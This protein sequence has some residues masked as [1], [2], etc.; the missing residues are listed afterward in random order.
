M[1]PKNKKGETAPPKKKRGRKP[2]NKNK[3]EVKPPPKKRGRKPKGGKIITKDQ[4]NLKENNVIEHNIILHLKCNSQNINEENTMLNIT[5]Y[6]PTLNDPAAYNINSSKTNALMF[7]DFKMEESKTMENI[8]V[9]QSYKEEKEEEK[10]EESSMKEIWLKLDHLK[11]KLK[12]NNVSDKK[13]ACFWCTCS[14]DNPAIYIPSSYENNSYEV[15]GCFCSPQCAVSFLKNQN[16][17]TSTLWER[18]SLLNNMY[19][20]IY[21]YQKNIKPAPNPFYTL[22][23]YYGNLSI[24][25]YRKLLKNESMYMIVDKPMTKI[26]PELYEENNETPNIYGNLLN[27][28]KNK[29]NMEYRLKRKKVSHT[30]S[31]LLESNFNFS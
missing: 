12:T 8:I 5:D 18:Y 14:F 24:S 28:N 16:I 4:L 13:S 7:D 23:K 10:G 25:E 15:Y 2:K 9:K 27:K 21:N 6:N 30:K 29:S 1:P 17:D 3:N 20:K 19:T 26:L 31:Q 22:D 11:K